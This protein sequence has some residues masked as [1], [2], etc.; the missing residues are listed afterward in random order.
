LKRNETRSIGEIL[1][2][3]KREDQFRKQFDLALI[4]ERWEEIA[5]KRLAP[6]GQP[7]GV[8][9]GKLYVEAASAVWMHRFGLHKQTI[10]HRIE[11]IAG[12]QLVTEVFLVL[13]D[14]DEEADATR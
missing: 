5:G 13:R 9:D 7:R 2:S 11:A 3:L 8:R 6:H 1:E 14:D 4:W 10:L 12:P